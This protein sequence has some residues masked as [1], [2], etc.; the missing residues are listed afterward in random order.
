MVNA[1]KPLALNLSNKEKIH[2]VIKI[3]IVGNRFTNFSFATIPN[4]EKTDRLN[5]TII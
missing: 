5:R 1:E 2:G 4:E 3:A